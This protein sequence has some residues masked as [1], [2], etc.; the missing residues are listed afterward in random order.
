MGGPDRCRRGAPW[1][2]W[3]GLQEPAATEARLPACLHLQDGR[4]WARI[5][6]DHHTGAMLDVGAAG[7]WDELFIGCPQVGWRAGWAAQ[8]CGG[9][10]GVTGCCSLPRR[11]PGPAGR[12]A[13]PCLRIRPAAAAGQQQA[14]RCCL[15]PSAC[16]PA[17]ARCAAPRLALPQ[18]L[19]AGP[20]DMRLYYNSWDKRR[21]KFVLGLAT[22]PDG[23]R[24]GGGGGTGPC[25]GGSCCELARLARRETGSA[26]QPP[27]PHFPT[28]H[29]PL[30]PHPTPPRPHVPPHAPAGGPRRGPSSRAAGRRLPLTPWAPRRTT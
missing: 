24:C 2:L 6:G 4:H 17:L 15:P 26:A 1:P 19:A 30:A 3:L 27:R 9:G 5:E 11:L 25:D 20:R 8:G 22:S 14:C 18:V 23:F 29:A 10:G 16:A 13:R 21:G 7:E 28:P 12:A